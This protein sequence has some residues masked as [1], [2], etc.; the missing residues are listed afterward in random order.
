MIA[1]KK[2]WLRGIPWEKVVEVNASFCQTQGVSLQVREPNGAAVKAQWEQAGGQPMGL[3]EAIEQCRQAHLQAPFVFNNANTFAAIAKSLVD[4]WAKGLP[5]V[6]AAILRTTLAHY[7]ADR[8]T[9]KELLQVFR[10]LEPVLKPVAQAQA[11][12]ALPADSY[13]QTA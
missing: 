5:A 9:Q 10:H 3:L 6:E 8:V 12:P 4:G 7:V 11:V 1:I 2:Q 13:V